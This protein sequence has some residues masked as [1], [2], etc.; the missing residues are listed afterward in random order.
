MYTCTVQS[1]PVTA[2]ALAAN[3]SRWKENNNY[4][5]PYVPYGMER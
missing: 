2:H 1:V 4:L 5:E 3:W